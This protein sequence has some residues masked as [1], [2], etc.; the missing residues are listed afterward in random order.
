MKSQQKMVPALVCPPMVRVPKGDDRRER[1]QRASGQGAS[2]VLSAGYRE[3]LVRASQRH[4]W[5]LGPYR[6]GSVCCSH[7]MEACQD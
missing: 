5:A 7:C 6:V 4:T 3:G 1:V 2:G